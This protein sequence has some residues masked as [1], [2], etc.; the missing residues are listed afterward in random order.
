M[1]PVG[2]INLLVKY[3]TAYYVK[4]FGIEIRKENNKTMLP[5][6]GDGTIRLEMVIDWE[7]KEL[8]SYNKNQEPLIPMIHHHREWKNGRRD[9]IQRW[10]C[11]KHN[12]KT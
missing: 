7:T 4:T 8:N 2:L 9:Q 12:Y 11:S 1:N 6:D 5:G 3:R 10:C